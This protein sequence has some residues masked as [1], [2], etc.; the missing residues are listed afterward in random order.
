MELDESKRTIEQLRMSQKFDMLGSR[1][2]LSGLSVK[3]ECDPRDVKSLRSRSTLDSRSGSTHSGSTLRSGMHDRRYA[4]LPRSMGI[5][6]E[7]NR[8]PINAVP[9]DLGN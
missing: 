2:S 5:I 6:E 9:P 1:E 7:N 8:L 3:S 4:T